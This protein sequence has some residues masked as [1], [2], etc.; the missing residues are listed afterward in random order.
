MLVTYIPSSSVPYHCV[1]LDPRD[2][3]V[4]SDARVRVQPQA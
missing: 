1:A 3:V 2:H 4:L